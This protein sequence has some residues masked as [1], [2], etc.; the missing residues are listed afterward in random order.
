MNMSG[1]SRTGGFTD[2]HAEIDAFGM[3]ELKKCRLQSLCQLH[4]FRRGVF[5]KKMQAVDMLIGHDHGMTRGIGK[6]VQ[7]D[8]IPLTTMD[9]KGPFVVAELQQ[10][11]KN[12][13]FGF[14]D[15]SDVGI[16]PGGPEIVH[17]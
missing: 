9:D 3:V 4:H 13:T 11:T 12:T 16:A 7:D 10:L 2:V 1:D 5:G 8:E 17:F 14:F 15:R 6:G